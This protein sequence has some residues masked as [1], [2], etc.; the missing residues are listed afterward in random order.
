MLCTLFFNKYR[1]IL[2]MWLKVKQLDHLHTRSSAISY[3][4]CIFMKKM[5]NA[6]SR[7]WQKICIQHKQQNISM[8]QNRHALSKFKS[9]SEVDL[10]DDDDDDD[11]I[12]KWFC[13]VDCSVTCVAYTNKNKN[14]YEFCSQ[15]KKTFCWLPCAL[16]YE[17]IHSIYTCVSILLKMN[18]IFQT[19]FRKREKYS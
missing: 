12:L 1:Q 17:P 16:L 6:Q 2:P 4:P 15:E 8:N 11:R 5:T 19:I 18:L 3:Y 14:L 13:V 9:Y 7:S 10:I